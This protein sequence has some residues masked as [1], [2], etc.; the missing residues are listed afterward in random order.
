MPTTVADVFRIFAGR[1]PAGVWSAPGRV[2]LIGEHTDYNDGVVMP[3]ALPLR[4]SVAGGRRH[5]DLICVTSRQQSG[6]PAAIPADDLAPGA[7]SG[8]PAYVAGVVWAL[9][10]DGHRIRGLDVVVDGTVPLGSGLASSAALE[11]AVALAAADLYGL[12]IEPARLARYA[13]QAENAFVGVPCGPMDQMVAMLATPGHAL[14]LDTRNSATEQLALDPAAS[15]LTVLVI[16]TRTKHAH[17]SGAYAERRHACAA[18]ARRLG[19]PALRDVAEDQL[20]DALQTL[21]DEPLLG[22]RVR[23]VVTEIARTEQVAGLLRA[24]RLAE[25]GPI[26]TASH[27]SLRDDFSVSAPELD[28]VVGTAVGAGALGAR[29]TGGGFGGC[30]IALVPA[31]LAVTVAAAV[32]EAAAAR[33]YPTPRVIPAIPSAGAGRSFRL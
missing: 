3:F 7:V 18:A 29:L 10:A 13:Q 17:A 19:V 33:S 11:C 25:I 16:D 9:R 24:A 12:D 22:R 5:D 26:L 15:G 30:A 23:H 20:A 2:N 28:L 4:V 21:S 32:T 27:R 8:W 31:D 14:Y 1:N 6:R